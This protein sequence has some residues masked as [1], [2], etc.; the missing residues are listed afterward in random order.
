MIT[1]SP[2]LMLRVSFFHLC[3]CAHADID[4]TIFKI[5]VSIEKCVSIST[6]TMAF[7]T[8]HLVDFLVLMA[9][10]RWNH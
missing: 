10:Y 8:A 3:L 5:H 9:I 6:R 4:K 1:I 7:G 2:G